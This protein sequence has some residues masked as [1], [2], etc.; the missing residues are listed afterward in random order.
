MNEK[1]SIEVQVDYHPSGR[2]TL[3]E[4]RPGEM[5]SDVREEGLFGNLDAASFYQKVAK[6]ISEHAKIGVVVSNYTDTGPN[7]GLI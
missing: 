6:R 4:R 2:L 1:R 3:K 5:W 7:R